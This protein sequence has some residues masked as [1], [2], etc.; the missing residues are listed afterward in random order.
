MKRLIRD[1]RTVWNTVKTISGRTAGRLVYVWVRRD[2]KILFH[3]YKQIVGETNYQ[4]FN[5]KFYWKFSIK[6]FK[7]S[8]MSIKQH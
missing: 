5:K 4:E 2:N 1:R 8:Q 6:Y 3:R 7:D